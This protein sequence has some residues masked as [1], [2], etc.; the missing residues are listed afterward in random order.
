MATFKRTSSSSSPS[1]WDIISSGKQSPYLVLANDEEFQYIMRDMAE[2]S[3]IPEEGMR[4]LFYTRGNDKNMEVYQELAKAFIPQ[5]LDPKNNYEMYEMM[6]DKSINKAVVSYIFRTLYPLLSKSGHPESV[7]YLNNVIATCV[8]TKSFVKMFELIG[9][10]DILFK[11]IGPKEN[12]NMF[13]VKEQSGKRREKNIQEDMMEAFVG[14]MEVMIDRYVKMFTGFMFINNLMIDVLDKMDIQYNPSYYWTDYQVIKETC[15]KIMS[16]NNTRK[17]EGKTLLPVYEF[18]QY[19]DT[20][21]V[22]EIEIVATATGLQQG[23]RSPLFTDG[24]SVGKLGIDDDIRNM[25][26]KKVLQK[27][28]SDP[29]YNDLIRKLPTAEDLGISSLV[30]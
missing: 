7:S 9:F 19:R 13:V 12:F 30:Q 14:C 6:G 21:A 23:A 24:N 26:A 10:N 8:S 29:T 5:A 4:A 15:D 25:L 2:R 1:T 11:V 28:S 27:L 16:A 22:Y 20:Y 3:G 18:G 17:R